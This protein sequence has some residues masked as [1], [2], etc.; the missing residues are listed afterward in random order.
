MTSD[1]SG[2][3]DTSHTEPVSVPKAIVATAHRRTFATR[4]W[5]LVAVSFVV[6]AVLVTMSLRGQG[7]KIVIH[8]SDGYGLKVGDLL[9]H[10][11]IA[12]GEVTSVILRPDLD[13]VDVTVSLEGPS[14]SL[15]R[16]GSQ[17]WIERPRISL[18]RVSGLET[19]VGPK[20]LGVLP[21][22]TDGPPAHRFE[23]LESPPTLTDRDFADI[24]VRFSEGFG[25]QQGDPVRHRGITVGE[26]LSVDLD[27]ELSRVLVQIRLSGAGRRLA[28]EGTAFWIERPRVSVTEVRGLETLVGGRFIA[29]SPGPDEVVAAVEFDGMDVVPMSEIPVG[30]I[31][32]VLHAPQRWGVDR[33]VPVTFRGLVVGQVDAV[34]LSSDGTN[35]EV[36]AHVD[37]RYRSLVRKNSVFWSS[38]GIDVN[39]GLT[40]LRMTADTLATIAQGGLAFATPEPPGAAAN[41]GQRFVFHKAAQEEWLSW[42][43]HIAASDSPLPVDCPSPQPQRA[44]VHWQESMLGFRRDLERSGWTLLLDDGRLIGPTDLL[45]PRERPFPETVLEIA[46]QKL[47]LDPQQVERQGSVATVAIKENLGPD[48]I[49]WKVSQIRKATDPEDCVVF[50]DSQSTPLPLAASSL[51]QEVTGWSVVMPSGL[52][53][54]RNGSPVISVKDGQLVGLLIIQRGKSAV[55]PIHP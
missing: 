24:T 12:V 44:V 36:R 33:G 5:W 13:G 45:L 2:E 14:G 32:L 34:G 31:E 26:V 28:R 6:A 1:S 23:G 17:F 29:A 50:G 53:P 7:P 55:I 37:A 43:P 30:A 18:S 46:G 51:R 39:L 47:I 48:V 20:H 21:G 15:A 52:T 38:S 22:P 3:A 49:K 54:L 27:G 25:L 10:R 11:G 41:S 42:H 9:L 4:L 16:R 19:V 8:F 35:V 40:G